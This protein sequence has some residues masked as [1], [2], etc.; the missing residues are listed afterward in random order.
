MHSS[1]PPNTDV[2]SGRRALC[3]LEL[4]NNWPARFK[5]L[6][7][8]FSFSLRSPTTIPLC[9]PTGDFSDITKG[10]STSAD[11]ITHAGK[12]EAP[13]KVAK[14]ASGAAAGG[15][16]PAHKKKAGSHHA[17][18]TT[19]TTSSTPHYMTETPA[20]T[21]SK[22]LSARSDREAKAR[23]VS[24]AWEKAHGKKPKK[25]AAGHRTGKKTAV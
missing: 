6:T 25:K 9:R 16:H 8:F 23:E 2:C 12:T 11:A 7:F 24:E 22:N 5:V 13:A 18:K 19:K 3:L 21:N 4:V 15:D 20:F 1:P 17:K 14:L 10:T